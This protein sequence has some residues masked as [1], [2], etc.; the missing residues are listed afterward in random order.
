M[1]QVLQRFEVGQDH[2]T[3]ALGVVNPSALRERHVEVPNVRWEDIGG[4]EEVKRELKETGAEEE[5][6]EACNSLRNTQLMLALS[7][8]S[9][10]SEANA[11]QYPLEHAAKY[12]K[13]GL[14]PSRGVLFYG[15]PGCGKTLL[16]KAVANECKANFISVSCSGAV[17]FLTHFCQ[18]YIKFVTLHLL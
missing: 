16:A 6:G 17:H 3:H 4:L 11:V 15:P 5:Y 18:T 13:F 1:L 8:V 14:S 7:S 10:M 2:F 12:R 9:R